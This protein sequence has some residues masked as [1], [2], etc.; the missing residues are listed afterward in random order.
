MSSIPKVPSDLDRKDERAKAIN[1]R[2]KGVD[3]YHG[4]HIKIT[5]DK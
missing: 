1:H 5:K 3:I 4:I 2:G